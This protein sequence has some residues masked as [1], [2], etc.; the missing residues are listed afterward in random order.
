[1]TY[2][3]GEKAPGAPIAEDVLSGKG[4]TFAWELQLSYGCFAVIN[5]LR[6]CLEH[7]T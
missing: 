6:M 2:R 3:P 7:H 5:D 1:M 4:G